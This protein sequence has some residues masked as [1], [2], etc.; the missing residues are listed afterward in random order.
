MSLNVYCLLCVQK[1]QLCRLRELGKVLRISTPCGEAAKHICMN[2]FSFNVSAQS[3]R[4][5]GLA[6]SSTP[7][8]VRLC[9]CISP[10]HHRASKNVEVVYANT[11]P[12]KCVLVLTAPSRVALLLLCLPLF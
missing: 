6:G 8:K 10:P 12:P 3:H 11:V 2:I 5:G 7:P 1:W 4:L 9:G